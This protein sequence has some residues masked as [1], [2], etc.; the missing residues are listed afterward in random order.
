MANLRIVQ[1]R[2]SH[3]EDEIDLRG[4]GHD[5]V[6]QDKHPWVFL[7]AKN[8]PHSPVEEASKLFELH[9]KNSEV[10]GVVHLY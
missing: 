8:V 7:S 10:Q 5:K 1:A 4:L 9:T 2:T 3:K 6:L